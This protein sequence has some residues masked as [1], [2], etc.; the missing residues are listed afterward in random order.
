M[1]RDYSKEPLMTACGKIGTRRVLQVIPFVA[2]MVLALAA[3]AAP[4]VPKIYPS[5]DAAVTALVEAVRSGDRVKLAIIFGSDGSKLISSGDA[6]ADARG[7]AAFVKAYDE[8]S[9]TVP[10]GDAKA[11]LEI[12]KDGWP[13]PIP[14]VKNGDGWEFDTRLGEQEILNRRIGRNELATIQVCLAIVDAERE[15]AA[16]HLGPDGVPRYAAKI[17]SS[18]GK[19][20]GLYWQT[21]P[22]EAPA[23]LGPLVAA[24]AEE[25]Y[26]SSRSAVLSPYHGYFYRILTA[27]GKDAPGGQYGYFVKGKMLGGF[28][29][30]AYPARYGASGIKTFIVNHDGIVYE[31]DLG[32]NTAAIASRMDAYNPD[33]TWKQAEEP[34]TQDTQ[35]HGP[36]G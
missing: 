20:D 12:G 25:G 11:V 10:Q 1:L 36:P 23:P 26:T 9:K 13:F 3:V 30:V 21:K 27:Q 16:S 22:D 24:A 5:P 4:V 15:Y 32:P 18:P 33:A 17:A 14:L 19:H 31:K 7:R 34:E 35:A 28:A 29:A 6:V 8:A 2:L